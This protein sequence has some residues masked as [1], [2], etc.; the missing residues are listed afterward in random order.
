[1]SIVDAHHHLW[2]PAV[3]PYPW[4]TGPAAPLRRRFGTDDLAA[5]LT[6]TDVTA[7]VVV[8]A[9]ADAGETRDLLDVAADD[10]NPV[11]GVVG[12]ADLTAPDVD[13]T[14]AHP[15]LAGV[16][17]QTHDEADPRWLLR[18]DVRRGLAAL[19]DR[20]LPFD[21]LIRGR[22]V[23]AALEL[24]RAEPRLQLVVDHAAKPAIASGDWS[25]WLAGLTELATFPQVS[26]KISGLVTEADPARWRE[27]GVVRYARQVIDL[28]GPDRTM[29]G[30]DWPVCTLAAS[31][32][33]VLDV[34]LDATRQLTDTD[35]QAV[36]A[37]TARRVYFQR[38]KPCT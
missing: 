26:C 23:P 38:R 10:A 1:M 22:E 5:T 18:P 30:S 27:Q 35:Q 29:F 17:H 12:W 4:M 14:L 20:G 34:A 3:R 6:G 28:F 7:T 21:L 37:D 11:T 19:R 33:D 9:V 8:Q 32:A 31:Y 15:S 13:D 16:R 25:G 24:A 36:L 2:D